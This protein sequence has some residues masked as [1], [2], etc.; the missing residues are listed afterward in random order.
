LATPETEYDGYRTTS[1]TSYASATVAG[2]AAYFRGLNPTLTTAASVKE[3]IVELAYPRVPRKTTPED[4]YPN[5]V[6]W[7]GQMNGE[8]AAGDCDGS[9][10]KR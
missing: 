9:K 2:L 8:S 6:I 4:Y 1:G 10:T 3:K 7:S 5:K